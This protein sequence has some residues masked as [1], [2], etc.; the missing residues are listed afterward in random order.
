MNYKKTKKT[1][2]YVKLEDLVTTEVAK[3]YSSKFENKQSSTAFELEKLGFLIFTC[4]AFE[5]A[6]PYSSI[7]F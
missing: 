2:L 3:K 4:H 6:S 7:P 1:E 5:C